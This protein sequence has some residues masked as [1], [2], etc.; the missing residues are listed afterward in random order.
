MEQQMQMMQMMA[1]MK[2]MFRQPEPREDPIQRL[3]LEKLVRSMDHEP[4]GIKE[5]VAEMNEIDEVI[6]RRWGGEGSVGAALQGFFENFADNMHALRDVLQAGPQQQAQPGGVAQLPPAQ[7]Q[8]AQQR[9]LPDGFYEHMAQLDDAEDAVDRIRCVLTA[10]Y[11]VQTE[12]GAAGR[13]AAQKLGRMILEN[14][15]DQLLSRM[16]KL[17]AELVEGGL[18]TEQTSVKTHRAFDSHFDQVRAFVAGAT[19]PKE[20]AGNEEPAQAESESEPDDDQ[21]AA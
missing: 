7:Q 11:V 19:G 10:L 16:K 3:M 5:A 20:Q 12:G 1:T 4:K 6:S 13:L 9:S 15:K 21:T 14:K 8:A 17:I 18:I 2:E